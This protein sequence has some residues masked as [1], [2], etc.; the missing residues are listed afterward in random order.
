M[1]ILNNLV[2]A[3]ITGSVYDKFCTENY[4]DIQELVRDAFRIAQHGDDKEAYDALKLS[5]A[6]MTQHTPSLLDD[7]VHSYAQQKVQEFLDKHPDGF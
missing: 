2:L 1:L 3:D 4:G 7:E 6:L 5:H